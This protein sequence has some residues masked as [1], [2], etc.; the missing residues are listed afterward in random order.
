MQCPVGASAF[1]YGFQ[2]GNPYYKKIQ[3]AN[4]RVPVAKVELKR[5]GGSWQQLVATV[6]NYHE[7]HGPEGEFWGSGGCAQVRLTSIFGDS[8][9]DSLCCTS[10]T[11]DGKAQFPCRSDMPGDCAGGGGGDMSNKRVPSGG[12]GQQQQRSG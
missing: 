12:S 1:K 8:V 5:G 2:G 7:A 11:C 6:D 9:E 10:S 4:A 3:V